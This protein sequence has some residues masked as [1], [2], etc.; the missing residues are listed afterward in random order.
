MDFQNSG[1]YSLSY[2]Q[3][4]NSVLIG[5]LN[6]G[7]PKFDSSELQ[8]NIVKVKA[9]ST[10]KGASFSDYVGVLLHKVTLD[11]GEICLIDS[12]AFYLGSQILEFKAFNPYFVTIAP[13]QRIRQLTISISEFTG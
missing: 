13:I 7:I 12:K 6:T 8:S 1:L 5:S 4:A 10:N 9:T 2:L 11:N 3:S